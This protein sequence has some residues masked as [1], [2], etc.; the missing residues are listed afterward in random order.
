MKS[1]LLYAHGTRLASQLGVAQMVSGHTA[2]NTTFNIKTN[3]TD[4]S[5]TS[6]ENGYFELDLTGVT[7][8]SLREMFAGQT[9]LTDVTL[10]IDTSQVTDMYDMFYNCQNVTTINGLDTLDT[11]NVTNM[12]RLFFNC[13]KWENFEDVS[14]W[15]TGSVTD[16]DRTFLICS[17]ITN[18]DFLSGWDT[19]SVTTMYGMFDRCGGLV[20]ATGISGWDTSSVTAFDYM[21]STCS[22]LTTVNV[23]GWDITSAVTINSMFLS[24]NSL[25][26][27]DL[28]DWDILN[29][30]GFSDFCPNLSTITV[31]YD[32]AIFKSAI[33][34]NRPNVNWIDVGVHTISGFA[35]NTNSITL[36]I[37]GTNNTVTPNSKKYFYYDVPSG[38]TLTSLYQMLMNA[39]NVVTVIIGKYIN[40]QSVTTIADMFAGCTS[41]TKIYGLKYMDTSSVTNFSYLF[42]G[43]KLLDS[44]EGVERWDTSKVTNMQGLVDGADTSKIHDLTP[45]SGWDTSKVTNMNAM[46]NYCNLIT[47]LTP[48]SGWN[49]SSV[50]DFS[51]MFGGCTGL[52]DISPIYGWNTGSATTLVSLFQGCNHITSVDLHLWNTTNVARVY[53][54]FFNCTRL[55]D[56]NLSGWV[57][58]NIVKD[59]T[60]SLTGIEDMFSGCSALQTVNM[61]NWNPTN[62][63]DISNLFKDCIKLKKL[64]IARWNTTGIPSV[65]TDWANF[66]PNSGSITVIRDSR[67]FK[68]N[69]ENSFRDV[70]WVDPHSICGYTTTNTTFTLPVND[71]NR[72]IT[73][74]SNGYFYFDLPSNETLTSLVSMLRDNTSV[75]KL[76]FGDIDVTHVTNLTNMCIRATGLTEI[77]GARYWNL[78]SCTTIENAF[79][80]C[81]SLASMNVKNW[82]VPVLTNSRRPFRN[83]YAIGTIDLSGWTGFSGVV[84]C[85]DMFSAAVS[86]TITIDIRT[87]DTRN[88][89][90]YDNFV[91]NTNTFTVYYKSTIFNSSI[92]S[93]FSS[94][95]WTNVA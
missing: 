45:I 84:D 40:T 79:N 3:G 41:L 43:T 54:M 2:A 7:L 42:S 38:T 31:V 94:V 29:T 59:A 24:C 34:T 63:K 8:T 35:S 61:E 87:L 56:V 68:T 93:S 52:T 95:K 44:L 82:N 12:G 66:I 65:S 75:T 16:M 91:R 89:T 58:A 13:N 26:F 78:S 19:S 67:I 9:S 14:G 76:W 53:D 74:D 86:S 4:R 18:L 71:I 88:V 77:K 28:S 85:L 25:T 62:I 36:K 37:N 69:I 21:F 48:I 81:T 15:D 22:S 49:T 83:L 39:S 50:Q 51:L 90:S 92:I 10:D 32:S 72:S 73:S 55:V 6:D 46:F 23:N 17:K 64:N 11:S 27:M 5:V 57:G 70:N 33:V 1:I 30:T 60:T 20:D 80:G 47:D